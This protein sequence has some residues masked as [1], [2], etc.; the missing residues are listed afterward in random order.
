MDPIGGKLLDVARKQLGYQAKGDGYSK[1]GEW[2]RKTVDGDHD[3]YFSTAPWCD[4]F[5]AWAA[6]Q[7]GVAQQAGQFASTIDH[8]KWFQKQG[9][10]GHTPEAG[11]LVFF[12]WSGSG[13]VDQTDHVG[14]VESV[15]G[16]CLHTIE[17][18]TDGGQLIRHVRCDDSKVVGYGYPGRVKVSE[19]HT[20]KHAAPPAPVQNIGA[21]HD[22]AVP[23]PPAP[24]QNIGAAHDAAVPAAGHRPAPASDHDHEGGLPAQEAV[25]GGVLALI[26]CGTVALSAGRA[27]AARAAELAPDRAPIRVRKRGKHHRPATPVALPADVTP[28]DLDAAASETTVMP[29]LSLAA[30]HEAEDREFWGRI[31][32]FEE[33]EDLAFWDDLHS[34]STLTSALS[35][36]LASASDPESAPA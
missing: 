18:N 20:P 3:S 9:A 17:G 25:M 1:Y 30:A 28:A 15:D 24:V 22:A 8:A 4:M 27:A 21:A 19:R 12:D 14:L 2:Y 32:H 36:T 7:A 31:A 16:D 10:F 13:D 34:E 11:A 33:D 29:A 23:A 5:L 6:Q 35:R 26:L